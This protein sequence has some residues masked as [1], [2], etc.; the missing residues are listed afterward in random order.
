LSYRQRSEVQDFVDSLERWVKMQERVLDTFRNSKELIENGDRLD[1]IQ[2]TRIAFN[3]MIRTL[4]AFDQWLQ[5]PFIVSHIPREKLLEV[6]R[7]TYKLLEELL[8]LDIKHTSDV[9]NIIY[10]ASRSGKL[11]P[12]TSKLREAVLGTEER[13]SRS[14][15]LSI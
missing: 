2:A 6:W 8:E 5:D 14:T 4:K 1:L 13:P 3:H 10:E 7:V 15:T 11:N 12:I 9:M